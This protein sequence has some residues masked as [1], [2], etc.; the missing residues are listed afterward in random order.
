MPA[1]HTNV[2]KGTSL[3][4]KETREGK[5]EILKPIPTGQQHTFSVGSAGERN[6]MPVV[7]ASLTYLQQVI[8]LLDLCLETDF[9]SGDHSPSVSSNRKESKTTQQQRGV[10][11]PFTQ[12]SNLQGLMLS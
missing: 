1:Q 3:S 2:I 6:T 5:K 12:N 11:H 8:L 10:N 7:R 9:C 4:I